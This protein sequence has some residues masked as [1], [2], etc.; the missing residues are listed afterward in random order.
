MC[1]ITGICGFEDREL[2][3]RMT[4]VLEHRGPD[5]SGFFFDKDVGL[6]HRRL[7]I[8][9]LST[10]KQ[11]I[12]NEDGSVWIVFNGE[13]YN[14]RELRKELEKEGHRFHTNSDTEVIVH[15]YEK[16]GKS[17]VESLR[18]MFA[19][20]IWDSNK[21]MLLLARDHAGIKPLYYRLYGDSIVFA[22]EIK[23]ILKSP[24]TRKETEASSIDDYLTYGFV[25]G[26]NTLFSGIKRLLP[27]HILIFEKGSIEIE[28]YWSL[29]MKPRRSCEEENKKTFMEIFEDSVRHRLISDVPLG[30]FLSGGLDSSSIVAIMSKLSDSPV[31]TFSIGFGETDDETGFARIV[32][33]KFGTEHHE[34]IVDYS[35]I[36]KLLPRLVWHLDDLISD[37]ACLPTF[38]VSE[39]AR[40]H[41]KVVLT[42][43]GSDEIFA[44]YPRYRYFRGYYNLL[45]SGLRL[46]AYMYQKTLFREKEKAQLCPILSTKKIT[47]VMK[48]QWP[49]IDLNGVM[50]YEINNALPHELLMKIDKMTMAN[51]LEARVP[52]LDI[53]IM[54]FSSTLPMNSKMNRFNGKYI[55]KK[56][57]KGILPDSIINRKKHGFTTPLT[58]WFGNELKE[59]AE[60][61]ITDNEFQNNLGFNNAYMKKIMP[62]GGRFKRPGDSYRV[63][64]LLM[65]NMWHKIFITN[66]LKKSSSLS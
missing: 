48:S 25:T 8:I 46:K 27:G 61:I 35:H 29:E 7:S 6:G 16:L 19:F 10:G 18:G 21:K 13:I 32:S 56:S 22:S 62:I 63:W 51:S 42:G 65:L 36:I 20:A 34:K 57:M 28:K 47:D 41:V 64:R 1:G 5:S 11:P 45:P 24:E 17:C 3:K 30:A 38:V 40:K 33:E 43:E 53:C 44:G 9:D 59:Y 23:S 49:Q 12:H 39:F 52:F 50:L 37:A 26:D 15:L 4:D 66:E 2:I 14:Y 31:K 55:L 58:L 54:E 60:Q